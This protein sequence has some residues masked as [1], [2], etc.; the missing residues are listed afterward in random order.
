MIEQNK[1]SIRFMTHDDIEGV[2]EVERDAFPTP[3]DPAIF[4]NEIRSNQFAHYLVYEYDGRI[5]RSSLILGDKD[6]GKNCFVLRSL[7]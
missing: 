7:F 3:W 1:A 2:M 4:H 5:L 6:V